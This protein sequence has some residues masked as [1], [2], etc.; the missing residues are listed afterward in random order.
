MMTV[1]ARLPLIG[2][3]TVRDARCFTSRSPSLKTICVLGVAL[4]CIRYLHSWQLR[5]L[6]GVTKTRYLNSAPNGK[7]DALAGVHAVKSL[8][9]NAVGREAYRLDEWRICGVVRNLAVS[10]GVRLIRV[11]GRLD[12]DMYVDQ[13]ASLCP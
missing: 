13:T 4:P 12:G 8:I 6:S 7:L 11:S 1:S 9:R 2:R 3:H 5:A 10:L